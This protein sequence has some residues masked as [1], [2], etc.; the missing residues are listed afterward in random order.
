MTLTAASKPCMSLG[1][2]SHTKG[3][4]GCVLPGCVCGEQA[5][6]RTP[7][8]SQISPAAMGNTAS[9]STT[10]TREQALLKAAHQ[11]LLQ[12]PQNIGSKHCSDL[13]SLSTAVSCTAWQERYGPFQPQQVVEVPVWLA[14]QLHK[15]NKARILLPQWLSSKQLSGA[16]LSK[17]QLLLCWQLSLCWGTCV[18]VLLP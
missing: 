4:S 5:A 16:A 18:G 2:G 9:S 15:C 3:V 11:A 8:I 7:A 12:R 17:Q 14:L 6:S 10:T 13:V 1:L